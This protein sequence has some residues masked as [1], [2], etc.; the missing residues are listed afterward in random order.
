MIGRFFGGRDHSTC[1][2][3][4]EKIEDQMRLRRQLYEQVTSLIHE[5][6]G[7]A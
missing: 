3:A 2:A 1:I 7:S 5:L 6:K 4:V